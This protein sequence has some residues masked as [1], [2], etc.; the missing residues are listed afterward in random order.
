[1]SYE[2]A[3][4]WESTLMRMLSRLQRKYLELSQ[5]IMLEN[6]RI[7]RKQMKLMALTQYMVTTTSE[8][9]KIAAQNIIRN[10][11]RD[12]EN[13]LNLVRQLEQQ[14]SMIEA[15]MQ[16]LIDEIQQVRMSIMEELARRRLARI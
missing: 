1:M 2:E 4:W 10:L 9:D 11:E 14:R 3:V 5:R 15:G 16:R 12:I 8:M 6:E 13:E 7:Q